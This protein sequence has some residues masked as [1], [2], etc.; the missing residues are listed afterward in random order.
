MNV[1]EI[2]RIDSKIMHRK[3]KARSIF[4]KHSFDVSVFFVSS[5]FSVNLSTGTSYTF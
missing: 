4:Q 1:Q 2:I 5:S 3:N